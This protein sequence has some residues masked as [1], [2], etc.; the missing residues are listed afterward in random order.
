MDL[1]LGSYYRT[2]NGKELSKENEIKDK[3]KKELE[4]C[5][6]IMS[7]CLKKQK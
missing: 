5:L 1:L 7:N 4:E 2:N 6:K 3:A